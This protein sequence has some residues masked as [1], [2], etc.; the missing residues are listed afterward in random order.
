MLLGGGDLHSSP[1][2]GVAFWWDMIM[3]GHGEKRAMGD[4][5]ILVILGT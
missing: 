5:F 1:V 2:N 3:S 4:G